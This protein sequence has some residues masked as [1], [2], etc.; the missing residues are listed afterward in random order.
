MWKGGRTISSH[1][2]VLIRVGINH[3]LASRN[4]YAY[5]HRIVAEKMLGRRLCSKE[6]IHHKDGNKKNNARSNLEILGSI[7]EH[8]QRHRTAARDLR[9]PGE[10]N[11][12]IKCKCG[13]DQSFR[14]YDAANRPKKYVSGHNPIASP[15]MDA[16]YK[17]LGCGPLDR[18]S[19]SIKIEIPVLPVA[20]ALSKMKNKG[21]VRRAGHGIWERI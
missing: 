2:Y 5:E 17:A 10:P 20:S 21:L 4:G 14:K 1:G 7:A 16:I 8:R 18:R 13:C 19:I 15:T 12:I 6:I 11:P 3:H 9:N